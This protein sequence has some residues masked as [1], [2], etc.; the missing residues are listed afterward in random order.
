[1]VAE[2]VDDPFGL[3]AD[4][5][6]HYGYTSEPEYE[7]PIGDEAGYGHSSNDNYEP[8]PEIRSPVQEVSL[9]MGVSRDDD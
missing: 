4:I 3:D 7:L 6:L 2:R 1:M 9:S 8:E 5:E